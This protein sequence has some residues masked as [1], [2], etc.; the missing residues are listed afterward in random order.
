[1]IFNHQDISNEIF[2]LLKEEK[3]YIKD[4][5]CGDYLTTIRHD[6]LLLDGMLSLDENEYNH[7][8]DYEIEFEVN[9]SKK[10]LKLSKKSSNLIIFNT[11]QI[12]QVK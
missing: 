11:H 4:L 7:H 5:Q 12:V 1:M 3:I 10:D 2:D 9:D 8:H 6:I